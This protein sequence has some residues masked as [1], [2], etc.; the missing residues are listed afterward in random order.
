MTKGISGVSNA[1]KV[2]GQR[3][4]P[5]FAIMS[6]NLEKIERLNKEMINAKGATEELADIMRDTLTGDAKAL[7]SAIEG[8]VL[9]LGEGGLTGSLRT[10]TQASTKFFRAFSDEESFDKLNISTK[11]FIKNIK[12]LG[13]V[14]GF[15]FKTFGFGLKVAFVA[16]DAIIIT[17]Q[18]L[19]EGFLIINKFLTSGLVKG[20]NFA[21]SLFGGN[22]VQ[23]INTTTIQNKATQNQTQAPTTANVGGRFDINL[24]NA[25]KG[26]NAA[27][28]PAPGN[29][30]DV[31]INNIAA[32]G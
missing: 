19:Q 8:N 22:N 24:I 10:A 17:I 30:L 4:A 9:G 32:G 20:F 6:K 26:I 12:F 23:N 2:F 28:T 1:F 7:L 14:I 27:F 18:S 21:K 11:V 5:A 25:P 16:L 29:K 15:V 3:G 13:S 31:G